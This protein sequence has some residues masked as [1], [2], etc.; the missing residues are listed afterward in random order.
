MERLG[1]DILLVPDH[2]DH[3]LGPVAAMVVAAE[4][5]ETLRIG[6]FVF[7]ND[8][9]HPA[10]L[11]K[12]AATIDLLT[13]GRFE[14]GMGAGWDRL[15]YEQ[16][17]MSF[18][19]AVVRVERLEEAVR[20]VKAMFQDGPV[21]FAGQ[22]YVVRDL[23]GWP[24][25]RQR[26]LPLLIGGGGRN[27]LQLAA[28]EADTIGLGLRF[29]PSG[30]ADLTTMSAAAT[31]GK[32]AWIRA[33]APETFDS[34]E[35]NIFIEAVVVTP[36][37]MRGA[38]MVADQLGVT[39]AQVLDSPHVLIGTIADIAGAIRAHWRDYGISYYTVFE[40]SADDFAAVVAQVQ[41]ET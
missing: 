5:T 25:P 23:E 40:K 16:S 12:E 19:P 17:G 22:H 10:L 36:D 20:I 31:R 13:D 34:L 9:R 7:N 11:A 24:K 26:P 2:F 38:A 35:L 14:L 21:T 27:V 37:R 29:L 28:R 18:S 4:A 6:S 3:Q 15:E 1:Y 32:L 39:P 33:A 8:C 41:S 30:R